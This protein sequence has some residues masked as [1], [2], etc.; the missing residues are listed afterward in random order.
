MLRNIFTTAYRSLLKNKSHSLLNMIGLTLGITSCLLIFLT[1]RYELSFDNFH[2]NADR[3]YRITTTIHNESAD[4]FPGASYPVGETVRDEF[5]EFEKVSTVYFEEEGIVKANNQ[6]YKEKG[7]AYISP[8][9]FDIFSFDWLV[10]NPHQ[11][12]EAPGAM[13]LTESLARNYFGID[14]T[15]DLASVLGKVIRLNNQTDFTVAGVTKDFPSNT[16]LPF[17][18]MLSLS[19]LKPSERREM[20]DWITLNSSVSHFVLLKNG[21]NPAKIEARFP[22][23]LKSHMASNESGRRSLQLQSLAKIHFDDRYG[24]YNNRTVTPNII[25]MLTLIGLFLLITACINF[26]NL[27]TAQSSKRSKEVGVRKVLGAGRAELIRKFMGEAVLITFAS[28]TVSFIAALIFFP[29]ISDLLGLHYNTKWITDPLIPVFFIGT[30]IVVST[31]S[32]LYPALVMSGFHPILAMKSKMSNS[33]APGGFSL[34]RGLIIF[35]FVLSQVLIIGT[36]VVA[37]QLNLFQNRPLGFDKEAIVT[38]TLPRGEIQQKQSLR[39]Q[40]LEIPGVQSVSLNQN[41]PSSDGNWVGVF[42]FPGSGITPDM[43]IVMRPADPS[44]IKT[45]GLTLLAGRDLTEND[46][47]RTAVIVNENVLKLMSISNPQDALGKTITTFGDNTVI[48]GVVK[49][50]HAFTL[51]EPIQPVFL[52][53][54]PNGARLAGIKI[55]TSDI[56]TTIAKIESIYKTSFPENIFEYQFLDDTIAS[57]YEEEKKLSHIFTVFSGI[58]IFIGC[59]G[60]F[61]LISFISMQRTKEIGIRKVNGARLAEILALLNRDFALWIAIAFVI[62]CPVAWYIMNTWL[63]KFA[64]KTELSWWIFALSG[65]LALGIALLT[66]SFQSWKA[67]TRN[68]VEA[69]RYE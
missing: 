26:V 17:R 22:E 7:I 35:Q 34:R 58:A 63:E 18:V 55:S 31:L 21:A 36:I 57:F 42:N 23:F 38:V 64:Y 66:V 40:L 6:I 53:N 28:L 5:A 37:R 11:A 14:K 51:Y 3:I 12:L 69:L 2:S 13:V 30:A 47:R 8:E 43:N 67:A 41:N 27:A 4:Y 60:L 62:A 16:D 20:T 33:I 50:F 25:L 61:G 68:P 52:F 19:T 45:Y 1:I 46:T 56:R 32:G 29:S 54:D 24:N 48:V 65:I 9:F 44:Y 49:D 39:N 15:G 10:G 59:L